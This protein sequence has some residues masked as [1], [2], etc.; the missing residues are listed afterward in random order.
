[1]TDQTILAPCTRCG[2]MLHIRVTIRGDGPPRVA[3][4]D[5]RH[6]EDRK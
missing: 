6:R 2:L 5:H 1:M 4:A 3:I